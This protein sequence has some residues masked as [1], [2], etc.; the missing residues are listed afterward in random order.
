VEKEWKVAVQAAAHMARSMGKMPGFMEEFIGEL[1]SRRST[2]VHSCAT[3][4]PRLP[5]M[6]LLTEDLTGVICHGAMY[7][8][9]RYN[10]R[11]ESIAYFCDTSGS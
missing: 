7:L 9:G 6:N 10:E 8:P 4:W 2:G 5:T 1:I 3:A 11:I